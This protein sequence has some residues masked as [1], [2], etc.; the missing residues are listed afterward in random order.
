M[1]G[2]A[3]NLEKNDVPIASGLTKTFNRWGQPCLLGM[4]EAAELKNNESSLISTNQSREA[5]TWVDDVMKRHGGTQMIVAQVEGWDNKTMEFD[6][7][8][9][10]GLLKLECHYPTDEEM[11]T[12]LRVWLT[13]NK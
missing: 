3:N 13:S 1:T 4:H 7:E 10:D 5:G 9:E 6:L 12:L 8:A 2:F 11:A